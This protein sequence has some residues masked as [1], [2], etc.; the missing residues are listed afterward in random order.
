[1]GS[2]RAL[3]NSCRV[4]RLAQVTVPIAS[5]LRIWVPFRLRQSCG[6]VIQ[7]RPS[8]TR[9]IAPTELMEPFKNEFSYQNACRLAACVALIYPSFPL[10]RF[11]RGLGDALEPL[12]LKQRM[13]LLADRLEACLP[14]HPPELFCILVKSLAVDDEGRGGLRGFLVWPL[15]E[16]VA[17]R[18]LDCFEEAMGALREMTRCFTAE[19]AIR[20]FLREHP[21]RTLRQLHAWCTDPHAHVRR[22][23]SEGSRPLLPWGEN[24]SKLLDPPHP[25]LSLLEKL[26]NDRSDYVRLSVSNHLNDISKHHPDLVIGTLGRWLDEASG[27]V[28]MEKIARHACRTLLKAGHCGALEL[29]GYGASE[30]LKIV[31]FHLLEKSVRVGDFLEYC[32]V[33]RNTSRVPIK[34]MFDYAIFHCKADGTLRPKV[35]K[36]RTRELGAGERW[37]IKG[38]HSFKPV[39]TRVY[40]EGEHG[41]EPRLNGR[42]F[43]MV[44]FMLEA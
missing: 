29:H 44:S 32:M 17:R 43:P 15:T 7:S 25:T 13:H 27:D 39:T 38:R 20:P 11:R 16:I 24:L 42:A 9:Q 36:G 23:V 41:I 18:G 12:E 40:H 28:R 1:M 31:K 33:I 19:F 10:A 34:V 21:E 6:A 26:K 8:A 2:A 4:N 37:E 22:L 30:S 3:T 35:F 14:N 5:A